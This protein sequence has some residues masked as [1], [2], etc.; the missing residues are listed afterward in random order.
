MYAKTKTCLE[1]YHFREFDVH[2]AKIIEKCFEID[3]DFAVE[4]LKTHSTLYFNYN[5]IQLAEESCSYT[6]LGTKCVQKYL[7]RKWF[8]KINY[9]RYS[10]YIIAGLVRNRNYF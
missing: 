3:E 5:P 10:R 9:W 4:I 2:A 8:G 6:F 7:D 1:L